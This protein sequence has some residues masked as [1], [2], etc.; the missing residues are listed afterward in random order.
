VEA[1]VGV[2]PQSGIDVVISHTPPFGAGDHSADHHIDSVRPSHHG[3]RALRAYIEAAQPPLVL[4]GHTHPEQPSVWVG[5]T[6]VQH[7]FDYALVDLP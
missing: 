7:V 6:L 3:W 4:H 5:R 2:W 1:L